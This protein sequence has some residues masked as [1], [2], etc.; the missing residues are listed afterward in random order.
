MGYNPIAIVPPGRRA[1]VDRLEDLLYTTGKF[2]YVVVAIEGTD[3]LGIQENSKS[4]RSC[5]TIEPLVYVPN[6][7]TVGGVNPIFLPI[8][9][10]TDFNKYEFTVFDRWGQ[11]VFRTNDLHQGWDGTIAGKVAEE[12]TYVYVI[13]L[14]DGN[15]DEITKRGHVTLLNATK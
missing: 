15:G 5:A 10:L 12:S 11:A 8:V 13:R 2:C 9:S 6:A 14:H 4:N 7:F 1:Y 3:T